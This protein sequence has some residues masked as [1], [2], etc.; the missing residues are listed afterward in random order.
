MPVAS[1][2]NAPS[3]STESNKNLEENTLVEYGEDNGG[4]EASL[5]DI[6]AEFVGFASRRGFDAGWLAGIGLGVA[7][8]EAVD[9][10]GRWV[11]IPYTH[12][13]GRWYERYRRMDYEGAGPKYLS[14]P[15]AKPRLY[16]PLHCGPDV[17]YVWFCEGEFNALAL[18]NIGVNAVAVGGANNWQPHWTT[19]FESATVLVGFDNDD[20]G[21]QNALRVANQFK[22]AAVFDRYPDGTNDFN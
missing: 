21:Q 5:L 10:A 8:P 16:N 2:K 22:T 9:F 12:K 19:M 1:A 7:A 20:V 14:P 15:G 4:A 18:I 11:S 3:T 13:T 17:D 6:D